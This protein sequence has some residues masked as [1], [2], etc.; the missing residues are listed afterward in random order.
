M[1]SDNNFGARRESLSEK[2]GSRASKLKKS[3]QGAKKTKADKTPNTNRKTH[4]T[5]AQR[6]A[7]FSEANKNKTTADFGEPESKVPGKPFDATTAPRIQVDDPVENLQSH[8]ID[9]PR[10]PAESEDQT[11]GTG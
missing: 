6:S 11:S 1:V 3:N 4:L 10:E 7:S 2:D 5:K 8:L 9:A